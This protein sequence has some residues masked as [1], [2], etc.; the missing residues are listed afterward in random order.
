ML[1]VFVVVTDSCG[2]AVGFKSLPMMILSIQINNRT[3]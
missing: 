1:D 2:A 3:R